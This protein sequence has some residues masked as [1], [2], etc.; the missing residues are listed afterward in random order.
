MTKIKL[1]LET[2][3][4]FDQ[5]VINLLDGNS[6]IDYRSTDRVIRPDAQVEVKPEPKLKEVKT[7]PVI[8]HKGFDANMMAIVNS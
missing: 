3:K 1:E 6:V 2:D 7:Q 4:Q 5:I 8:S